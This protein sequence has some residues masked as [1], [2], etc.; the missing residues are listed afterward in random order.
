MASQMHVIKKLYQIVYK[1]YD[2]LEYAI[3]STV[4]VIFSRLRD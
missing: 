3:K 2:I 4:F 1:I